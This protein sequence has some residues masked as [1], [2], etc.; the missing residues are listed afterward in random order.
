ME[1]LRTVVQELR[2]YDTWTKDRNLTNTTTKFKE[3]FEE[4]LMAIDKGDNENLCEELGDLL[5]H[6]VLLCTIAEEKGL[7]TLEDSVDCITKKMY[8][9]HLKGVV[10]NGEKR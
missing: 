6:V 2:A 8:E 9:R 3:E 10:I 5:F 1:K 7:F 4:V